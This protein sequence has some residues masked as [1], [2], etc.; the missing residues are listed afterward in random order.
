MVLGSLINTHI[1]GI[2]NDLGSSV[3]EMW[4]VIIL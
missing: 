1:Y 2:L 4:V 3:G